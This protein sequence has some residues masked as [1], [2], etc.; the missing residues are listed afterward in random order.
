MKQSTVECAPMQSIPSAA[1]ISGVS[2]HAIRKLVKDGVI[3]SFNSGTKVYV[4]IPAL[5]EYLEHPAPTGKL[6]QDLGA[7]EAGRDSL[8]I[9]PEELKETESFVKVTY[10]TEYLQ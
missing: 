3:T 9:T 8:R 5:L 6:A 1:R 4:H 7:C 10:G 2:Q